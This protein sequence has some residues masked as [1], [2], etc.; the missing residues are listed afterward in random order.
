VH[1]TL[2]YRRRLGQNIQYGSSVVLLFGLSLAAA[3]LAVRA[4]IH[5]E[6][7]K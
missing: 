2:Q 1:Q 6:Y 7:I 4:K 5:Q 3:G